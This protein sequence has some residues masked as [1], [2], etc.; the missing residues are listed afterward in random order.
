MF[1]DPAAHV[2]GIAATAAG[3]MHDPVTWF[4]I[5]L[6]ALAGWARTPL[7][8]P[9][10]IA[11]L[12]VMLHVFAVPRIIASGSI[13]WIVP[14]YL[15]LAYAAFGLGRVIPGGTPQAPAS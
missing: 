5:A 9:A 15:L 13:W 3:M 4:C 2:V 10:I 11:I 14:S 12:F 1:L 8:I 6:A 7:V